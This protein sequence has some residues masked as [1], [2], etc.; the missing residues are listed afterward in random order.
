MRVTRREFRRLKEEFH[1]CSFMA[2]RRMWHLPKQRIRDPRGGESKEGEH[3]VRECQAMAEKGSRSVWNQVKKQAQKINQGT[4]RSRSAE[5]KEK[6]GKFAR[7]SPTTTLF[8]EDVLLNLMKKVIRVELEFE[9]VK[10]VTFVEEHRWNTLIEGDEG[11]Q[12]RKHN[13]KKDL[14]RE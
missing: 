4:G 13:K 3:V 9:A 1:D 2:Q 5:S 6:S 10:R 7:S 12:C 14:G 8:W 11:F